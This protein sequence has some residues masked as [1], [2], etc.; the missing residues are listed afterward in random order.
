MEDWIAILQMYDLT[1]IGQYRA[2]APIARERKQA[3][4]T[5]MSHCERTKERFIAEALTMRNHSIFMQM[6]SDVA[7]YVETQDDPKLDLMDLTGVTGGT[8]AALR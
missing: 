8:F 6:F 2:I 5:L 7:D 3:R 4:L 1:Q